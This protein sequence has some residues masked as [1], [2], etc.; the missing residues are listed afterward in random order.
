MRVNRGSGKSVEEYKELFIGKKF[1]RLT[2]VS[3]A[4][5]IGKK[6]WWNCVCDCGKTA[7]RRTESLRINKDAS[8][9]CFRTEKSAKTNSR[10]GLWKSAE[11]TAYHAM[12]GRCYRPTDKEY[13]RYGARG[14]T[15][16]ERWL[17]SFENFIEDMGMRP[18]KELSLDRINN[19]LGYSKENCRWATKTE[20]ANNFRR[21]RHFVFKGVRD[22]MANHCRGTGVNKNAILHRVRKGMTYEEAFEDC[23]RVKQAA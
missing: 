13:L 17:E 22:T 19:D 16:C 21:N 12:K 4:G 23:L 10:H 2:V 9:G 3:Y 5:K 1:S 20:Q 11:Y 7:T 18:D 6:Q 14:I 15:V 8:C